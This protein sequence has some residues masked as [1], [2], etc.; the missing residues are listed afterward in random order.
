MSHGRSLKQHL[1]SV[2]LPNGDGG[3]GA[4]DLH[5]RGGPELRDQPSDCGV[6]VRDPEGDLTDGPEGASDGRPGL[7]G[8]QVEI[9]RGD[10][11]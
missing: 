9:E 11:G 7:A 5:Q 8:V 3:V 2:S 4:G 1:V 6:G 10:D